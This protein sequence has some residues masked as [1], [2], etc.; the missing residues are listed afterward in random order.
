MSCHLVVFV[1]L[2]FRDFHPSMLVS[3]HFTN[4]IAVKCIFSK[5]RR[6]VGMERVYDFHELVNCANTL[7]PKGPRGPTRALGRFL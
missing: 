1:I 5:I 3:L 4:P 7:T 2:L 6:M